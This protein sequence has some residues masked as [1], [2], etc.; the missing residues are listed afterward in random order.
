MVKCARN[1]GYRCPK[2][3]LDTVEQAW[4]TFLNIG[5]I[6]IKQARCDTEKATQNSRH[7]KYCWPIAQVIRVKSDLK[8]HVTRAIRKMKVIVLAGRAPMMS[9][10]YARFRPV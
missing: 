4:H 5:R 6:E 3:C 2:G 7:P 9:Y 8:E 1:T 10:I